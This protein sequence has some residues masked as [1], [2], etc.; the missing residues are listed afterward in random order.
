LRVGNGRTKKTTQQT[1][2]CIERAALLLQFSILDCRLLVAAVPV[3]SPFPT[4]R[5]HAKTPE[6]NHA[7]K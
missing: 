7:V 1:I 6:E 3:H 5:S 4:V 2:G